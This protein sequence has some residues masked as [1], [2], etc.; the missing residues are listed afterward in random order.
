MNMMRRIMKLSEINKLMLYLLAYEMQQESFNVLDNES[1][2]NFKKL[3]SG[4]QE[5]ECVQLISSAFEQHLSPLFYDA[6]SKFCPEII[7]SDIKSWWQQQTIVSMLAQVR[8]ADALSKVC[9][10]FK[11]NNIPYI[12]LKGITCRR[13]YPNPNLRPS[14]DEDILIDWHDYKKCDELLRKMGYVCEDNFITENDT[15]TGHFNP[16]SVKD[17]REAHYIDNNGALYLEVHFNAIGK[18][19]QRSERMNDFFTN[20]FDYTC[21]I[22]YNGK[23]FTVLEPTQQLMHL[24]AHFYRHFYEQGVGIRQATDILITLQSEKENIN[25]NVF[26]EFLKQCHTKNVFSA[27]LSIGD[28][29]LHMDLRNC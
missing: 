9:K 26:Y 2:Q 21:D 4:F 7:P 20:A 11:E 17:E 1:S 29:Y 3:V 28:K 27:I 12:V 8:Q 10:V 13:Y 23:Q 16:D 15:I 22:E 6:M 5:K 18:E 24:L 14:S 19:N 25:W